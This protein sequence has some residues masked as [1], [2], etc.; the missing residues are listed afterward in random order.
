MSVAVMASGITG[1]TTATGGI[2]GGILAIPLPLPLPQNFGIKYR[3]RYR[4]RKLL[5]PNTATATATAR[6]LGKYRYRYR[7]YWY[8]A[9]IPPV[10]KIARNIL[11]LHKFWN[12]IVLNIYHF[13]AV[14]Y[15]ACLFD[16]LWQVI[17]NKYCGYWKNLQLSTASNYIL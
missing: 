2:T 11:F 17:V 8:F 10:P 4:Y 15:F 1:G 16:C 14:L 5:G 13:V 6:F 9:K 7:R 12:K 3:Y